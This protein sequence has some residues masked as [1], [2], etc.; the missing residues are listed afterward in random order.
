V[1]GSRAWETLPFPNNTEPGIYDVRAPAA[2]G[3]LPPA[4]ESAAP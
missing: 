4:T 1:S 3:P 2:P